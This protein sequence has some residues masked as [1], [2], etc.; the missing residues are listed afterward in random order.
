M[1]TGINELPLPLIISWYEQ[2][3]VCV[4]HKDLETILKE[5]LK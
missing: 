5:S 1:K 3:I 4:L 2:K